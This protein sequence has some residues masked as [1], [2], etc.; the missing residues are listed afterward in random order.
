MLEELESKKLF[1]LDI[2]GVV[3]RGRKLIKNSEKTIK[4][5]RELGKKLVFLSNTSVNSRRMIMKKF[6]SAGIKVSED[7]LMLGTT[8]TAAYIARRSP[9]ARVFT[10]GGE[11]LRE[12]LRA[13]GLKVVERVE[14]ADYFVAAINYGINFELLTKALRACMRKKIKYI[15]VNPDKVA[16]SSDGLIPGT[17][18]I[19][20]ALYWVTGR[21]PDVIIGKPSTV[22]VEET[23]RRVGVR[24]KHAVIIGDHPEIDIKVAN[25]MG[26][27]SVLVLSGVVN[28][29]NWKEACK[30]A[31]VKPDVVIERLSK[32]IE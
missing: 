10:T 6:E 19:V 28:R 27:T 26:I 7:E 4:R 21:K 11:G 8:A 24:R 2:D 5:L 16:P 25:R 13:F 15:A 31:G 32:L 14:I 23:L 17:G 18:F 20:G 29:R 30:K 3:F 1:I 12:E 9:R 22:I